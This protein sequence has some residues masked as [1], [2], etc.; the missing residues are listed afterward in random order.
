LTPINRRPNQIV[1]SGRGSCIIAAAGGGGRAPE[2]VAISLGEPVAA[3]RVILVPLGGNDDYEA[4]LAA[5]YTIARPFRAHIEA[6]FVRPDPLDAIADLEGTGS[7]EILATVTKATTV[8]WD[9]Y[10][11]RAKEAF[12][13]ARAAADAA[14]A[15][16][17]TGTDTLTSRWREV[18]GADD[19]VIP[20]HGRLA[21]LLVFAGIGSGGGDPPQRAFEAALMR[22]ARP[23]LLVPETG[24]GPIGQTIAIAWN[25]SAEAARAVAGAMPLLENAEQVHIVTAA[26]THTEVE[27]GQA[28][29]DY[30]GWHGIVCDRHALYPETS[31]GAA[32]L[33][34]TKELGADLLVMGGYGHSRMRELIFGGATL[35]VLGHYDL[36]VLIA[37]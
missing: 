35:H 3:M 17:S 29:A 13:A 19:V 5:A 18:I 15:D 27:T 36:P 9:A 34:R 21:D 16:Q 20:E 8:R 11:R 4:A 23:V 12:D 2:G 25:G 33:A 24:A 22:G 1:Q 7:P 10:A 32:L 6:L 28:L 37:H 26:G 14:L 31:V 30:L